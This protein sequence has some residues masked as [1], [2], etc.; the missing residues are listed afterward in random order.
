MLSH[1]HL[2][3]KHLVDYYFMQSPLLGDWEAELSSNSTTK[4]DV[5]I[6]PYRT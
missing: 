3:N 4:G 5:G 1:Y 2:V 6:I